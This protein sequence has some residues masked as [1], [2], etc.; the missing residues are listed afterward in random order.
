M[1]H[2]QDTLA[3]LVKGMADKAI[4][5]PDADFRIKANAGFSVQIQTKYDEKTLNGTWHRTFTGSSPEV[6]LQLAEAFVEAL[7]DPETVIMTTYLG[8][9]AAAVDYGAANG[10]DD[11]YIAPVRITRQAMSDNLLPRPAA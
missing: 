8:K 1:K 2:I 5:T 7:P 9:L 4:V 3:R 11:Q 10:I 6:A